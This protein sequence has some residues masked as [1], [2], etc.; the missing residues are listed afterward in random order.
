MQKASAPG[1]KLRKNAI[2]GS[3]IDRSHLR[4]KRGLARRGDYAAAMSSLPS[5]PPLCP[6][7][8]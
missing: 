3:H 8:E 2:A 6:L 7:P 4:L 5:L 1:C